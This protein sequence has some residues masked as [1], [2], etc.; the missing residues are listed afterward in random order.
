MNNSQKRFHNILRYDPIVIIMRFQR[1]RGVGFLHFRRLVLF[2]ISFV[3]SP[4]V[5][6]NPDARGLSRL[7]SKDKRI[8][9]NILYY[10]C[11]YV[12]QSHFAY[13]RISVAKCFRLRF[14]RVKKFQTN[15]YTRDGSIRAII[16]DQ[17][18]SKLSLLISFN[19]KYT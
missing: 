5:S 15:K 9:N 6:L 1:K 13:A 17:T 19:S 12:F 7:F 18:E 11:Y 4:S 14:T 2:P 8:R 3:F 16:R 10:C